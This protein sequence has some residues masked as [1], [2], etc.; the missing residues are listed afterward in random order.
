MNLIAVPIM[1]FFLMPLSIIS[2]FLMIFGIDQYCLKLVGFFINIII[3]AVKFTNTLPLSVWYFSYITKISLITFLFGFFW[4]CLWRTKW[5]FLGLIIMII[6]VILMLN[7]PKP[8]F[9]FDINLNAVGIKNNNGELDIYV[10]EMSEFKR[11][12][13]AN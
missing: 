4:T 9:I 1:S 12:Y 13:W 11:I 5:H 8:N 7:S 10:N 3:A 2:L 6:S